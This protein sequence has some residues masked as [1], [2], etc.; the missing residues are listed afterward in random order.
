MRGADL[1]IQFEWKAHNIQRGI[2]LHILTG[3]ERKANLKYV[4]SKL[5]KLLDAV[6]KLCISVSQNKGL[7]LQPV[8]VDKSW[9][10]PGVSKIHETQDNHFTGEPSLPQLNKTAWWHGD[11]QNLTYH[12]ARDIIP[13]IPP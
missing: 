8:H 3:L 7:I 6:V 10:A 11:P 1:Y 4:C 9:I 13:Q 12:K 2:G 5:I